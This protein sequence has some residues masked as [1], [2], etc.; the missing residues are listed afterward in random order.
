MV[1]GLPF[2]EEDQVALFRNICNLKYLP[3][4][5]LQGLQGPHQ[6]AAHEEPCQEAG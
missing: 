1:T 3:K 5:P 4:T 2:Y 6:E